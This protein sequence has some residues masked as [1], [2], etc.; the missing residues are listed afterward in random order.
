[1]NA[2]KERQLPP[3]AV[4]KFKSASAHGACLSPNSTFSLAAKL[5]AN[6]GQYWDKFY[7]FHADKF[8]NDRHWFAEE[9][10]A[11][12]TATTALEVGCGVGNS[13]FPLLQIN[14]AVYVYACDFA[15]TGV[16]L[17]RQHPVYISSG[18]AT[19]F[20][21][22]LTATDL[23]THVPRGIVDACTMIF[24]LSAISPEAMPTAVANVARTLVPGKGQV[25]FRD[26]C[27]GDL[28]QERLQLYG[29]QQRIGEGFYMR[30]DGTRA[31]YFTENDVRGLFQNAGFR[32]DSLKIIDR[33]Q[34]NRNTGEN[35]ER[36]FVQGVFT[37]ETAVSSQNSWQSASLD[38]LS[39]PNDGKE[40]ASES[41]TTNLNDGG[42]L[43]EIKQ[44]QIG[45]LN[46]DLN[47]INCANLSP[48]SSEVVLANLIVRCP[49]YF[50]NRNVVQVHSGSAALP[51]LA[52]LRWCRRALAV[53]P[54]VE[55]IDKLRCNAV[56]N[57]W[58]FAYERL[59][60]AVEP[61]NPEGGWAERAFEG[62]IE[63]VLGALS[64]GLMS[65]N[66]SICIIDCINSCLK[67]LSSENQALIVLVL[68]EKYV[69]RAEMEAT[70]LGLIICEA[71]PELGEGLEGINLYGNV[72]V[73]LRKQRTP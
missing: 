61:P 31:Y 48:D 52:T 7:R 68:G 73:F 13:V 19:A 27:R 11:L 9:F 35:R 16:N 63:L 57:G 6:A 59:R 5:E 60:V 69:S 36:K 62:P 58:Q 17:V 33:V 34:L 50:K 8:F 49:D 20:V 21:A 67:V 40:H 66:N 32:C 64:E 65:E 47:G 41:L 39:E 2:F 18:R 22:D 56:R 42:A 12:L 24:V 37:L 72:A 25:L 43:P 30:G 29:K 26:Y 38:V 28:A 71:P 3:S 54:R 55:E 23:L 14:P 10:P 46:L 44:I 4:G 53:D 45:S 51:T 15:E 70:N 1:M